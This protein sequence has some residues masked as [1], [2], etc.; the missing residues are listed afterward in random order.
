MSN[1]A[2]GVFFPFLAT[3]LAALIAGAFQVIA[4]YISSTASPKPPISDILS[5]VKWWITIILTVVVAIL[6]I[7]F[8][9]VQVSD[10]DQCAIS[11]SNWMTYNG[12]PN[13]TIQVKP[14]LGSNCKIEVSFDL[15][16]EGWA[17]VY[18]KLEPKSLKWTDGI[19][20]SYFI[21]IFLI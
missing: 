11:N 10:S 17:A 2:L 14:A 4:A 13:S 9:L 6:A 18:K 16:K 12:G 19:E 8:V 15:E 7:A 21:S 20:F 1:T 3:I 5:Q